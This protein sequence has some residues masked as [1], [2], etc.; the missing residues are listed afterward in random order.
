MSVKTQ[1]ES[2]KTSQPLSRG[3]TEQEPNKPTT[4]ETPELDPS[5]PFY[6]L[7]NKPTFFTIGSTQERVAEVMGSPTNIQIVQL[8]NEVIWSYNLSLVTFVNGRVT[9]WSDLSRNL[10]VKANP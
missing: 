8:T 6:D 1:D 5:N 4:T 7:P 9:K 3:M 10:K 2:L